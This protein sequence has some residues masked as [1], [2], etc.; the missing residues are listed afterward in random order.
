[1]AQSGCP[2][3]SGG[4]GPLCS[5]EGVVMNLQRIGRL[6]RKAFTREVDKRSAERRLWGDV[7]SRA[8]AR[9]DRVRRWLLNRDQK[10]EHE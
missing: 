7:L 9:A 3:F 8:V 5:F 2:S 6:A 10:E 4:G 1:M